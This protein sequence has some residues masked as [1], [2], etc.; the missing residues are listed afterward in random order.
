MQEK[1]KLVDNPKEREM[2]K[3]NMIV[4][5]LVCFLCAFS[6]ICFGDEQKS[7]VNGFRTDITG[8]EM[9]VWL[10]QQSEQK[11]TWSLLASTSG[12][13]EL[14]LGKFKQVG[15]W[16][17]QF[18]LCAD[19]HVDSTG[20]QIDNIFPQFNALLLPRPGIDSVHAETWM[21]SS[22]PLHGSEENAHV[23]YAKQL[24]SNRVKNSSLFVGG[25]FDGTIGS[26]MK[27]ELFA[28]PLVEFEMT[29]TLFVGGTIQWPLND[30]NGIL[31]S[32]IQL[33]SMLV[34]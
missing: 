13:L 4:V 10:A 21:I 12:R 15:S 1:V 31:T 9:L 3:E 7:A 18:L 29:E 24:G 8:D 30:N 22:F 14:D 2:K 33:T 34:F 27:S 32:R 23:W 19:G 25:Q 5:L 6:N 16:G 17:L 26:K 28:G 20:F 11:P